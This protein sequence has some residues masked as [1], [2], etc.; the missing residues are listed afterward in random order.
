VEAATHLRPVKDSDLL[1]DPSTGQAVD[2]A[3][4]IRDLEDE[5]A[6]L[7]STIEKQAR[8]IGALERRVTEE[9]DPNSHPKGKEIVG[10]I[11]RW[12]RGSGH[13]KAKVSADRIKLVK[14]RLRDDYDLAS[15]EWLPEEPTIELAV[16]GICAY[17]FVVNGSRK[18]E[19]KPSQR[20]DRLGIALAGGEKVE[21]F[22]RLGYRARKE[23]LV[24]WA[25]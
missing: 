4:K 22:S 5:R 8:T 24:T 25:E 17:P 21:E 3:Y 2:A 6:G 7:I 1:V 11:V 23:G 9:E 16:D 15:D 18:A 10:V 12:M 13:T 20:H 19:G 14:A